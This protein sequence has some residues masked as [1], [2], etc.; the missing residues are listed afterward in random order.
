MSPRSMREM[1]ARTPVMPILTLHDARLAGDLAQA[2][3][4][5]GISVFEVVMRTP[6]SVAALRTMLE[7]AP[8]ADIGMGTL[9]TPEDVQLSLIHI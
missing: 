1:L 7:A 8:E 2:L 6:Q 4:R 5:G 9:M 3:V